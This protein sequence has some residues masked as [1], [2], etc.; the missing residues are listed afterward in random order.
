MPRKS[1]GSTSVKRD[2]SPSSDLSDEPQAGK[3][4]AAKA[5]TTNG[6]PT[7]PGRA[8]KVASAAKSAA[9]A[10]AEEE[11]DDEPVVKKPRASKSKAKA[12]EEDTADEEV[13]EKTEKP[14][15]GKAKPKAKPKAK[16]EEVDEEG[17]PIEKPKKKPKAKAF[18]PPDLEPSSHPA[19]QGHPVFPLAELSVPPNGGV[20]DVGLNTKRPMLLGAHVSMAGGPA[21]ALLRAGKAGANGLALFLKSQRT[22]KSTPY[23]EETIQ[24]FRDLMRPTDQGGEY[25]FLKFPSII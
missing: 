7:R 20:G 9:A 12:K 19:R 21:A 18:P 23:E 3:K 5:S 8:S 17:N 15:K 14:A 6:T 1:V 24:R 2:R 25:P 16:A 10:K 4:T 11:S 22:W 13:E